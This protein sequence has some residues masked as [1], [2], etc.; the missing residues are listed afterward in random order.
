MKYQDYINQ[1]IKKGSFLKILSK[2]NIFFYDSTS[3]VLAAAAGLMLLLIMLSL[4]LTQISMI[5]GNIM[6]VIFSSLFCLLSYLFLNFRFTKILVAYEKDNVVNWEFVIIPKE[7]DLTISEKN[8]KMIGKKFIKVLVKRNNNYFGYDPYF[9]KDDIPV[10]PQELAAIT[11]QSS[12]Q[13]LTTYVET[14]AKKEIF[15][16]GLLLIILGGIGFL[17][18]VLSSEIMAK[19]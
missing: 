12:I 13:R 15:E 14:S 2:K 8:S 6:L 9:F 10:N 19:I 3:I 1:Y 17:I 7:I 4:Y 16:K 11:E 5:F 18:F